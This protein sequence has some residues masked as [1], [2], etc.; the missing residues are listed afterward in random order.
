MRIEEA[1]ADVSLYITDVH[2]PQI[3]SALFWFGSTIYKV[4][5]CN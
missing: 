1:I 4:I 5:K 3:Y 2:I